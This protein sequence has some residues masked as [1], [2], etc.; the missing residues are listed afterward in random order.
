M[1][2]VITGGTG[3][4]GTHLTREL[5]LQGIEVHTLSRSARGPAFATSHTQCSVQ[6][7]QA[8]Q[9]AAGADVI[10]HLAGLADA[11][12]SNRMPYAYA[13]LH[14]DGTLNMLEA[15]RQNQS[16]F[17]LTSSQRVYEQQLEPIIEDTHLKP[18]DAYGYSKLVAET[19]VTMYRQLYHLPCA[20][21]RLFSVFGPGQQIL[22]G[23]S[24]VVSILMGKALA[25]E[26]LHIRKNVRRDFTFIGDV[27]RGIAQLIS[28]P[29]AY[30][31]TYNLATGV[32]TSLEDLASLVRKTARSDSP[33]VVEDA[34][35]ADWYIADINR[36]RKSFNFSPKISLADGITAYAKWYKN[37]P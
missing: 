31:Q 21:L 17:I 33:V 10:V 4:I 26:T 30:N 16:F 34:N 20:I 28:T 9:L 19:W 12:S 8:R 15:A 14:S 36:A 1:R 11:S 35:A 25:G 32:G 18:G 2:V 13:E 29:D 27:V 5:S 3:F 37:T 22:A 24:G 23:T 6:S 7:L